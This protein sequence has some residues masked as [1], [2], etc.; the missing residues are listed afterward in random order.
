MEDFHYRDLEG[1]IEPMLH[2]YT[3][4]PSLENN[5]YLSVRTDPGYMRPVMQQLERA[6]KTMPSRR[7]FSYD[8]MSE[9]VDKQYALLD[10]IL[11]VSN[12]IALLTIL[13]ASMGMFGLISLFARQRVKEIGIRKVLGSDVAGIVRLLSRDFVL[14]VTIAIAFAVPLAWYVMAGWLHSFAYH[15]S[16]R[17]WMFAVAGLIALLIT[18]VTVGL[19]ATRAALANPVKSLRSE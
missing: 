5:S 8:L 18:C 4:K 14:L 12:F 17:W 7:S 3:G 10:G 19:Q 15:I 2:W 16:I 6:F 11:K 1:S 9:R 13:I